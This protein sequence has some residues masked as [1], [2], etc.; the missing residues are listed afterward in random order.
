MLMT[1]IAGLPEVILNCISGP[2]GNS[3]A[4]NC[5]PASSFAKYARN[6]A[7]TTWY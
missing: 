2:D 5:Y 3:G 7:N 6:S 1:V 4:F